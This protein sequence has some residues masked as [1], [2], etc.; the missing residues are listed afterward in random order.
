MLPE[1]TRKQ[2]SA[3]S[4]DAASHTRMH[5][6]ASEDTTLFLAALLASMFVIVAECALQSHA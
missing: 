2:T 4:K 5:P 1:C 6:A 3:R